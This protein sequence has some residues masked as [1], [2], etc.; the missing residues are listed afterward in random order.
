MF[1]TEFLQSVS[2]W[3][4]GGGSKQKQRRGERL[5]AL[6]QDVDVRFRSCHFVCYRQMALDNAALWKLLAERRLT[7]TISA[8]TL[9]PGV[10]KLFKGGVPYEGW[11]GV[12][13]EVMPKPADVILNLNSLY[14]CPEF[15][16]ALERERASITGY[17][18]GAGR[19]ANSQSEVVLRTDALDTATVYAMGGFSSDRDTLIR[20]MFG[21]EPTADL[22]AW[23]EEQQKL[24]DAE[25]GPAWLGGAPLQRVLQRMEPHIERLKVVKAEQDAG[26]D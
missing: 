9:V 17:S 25:L 13:F 3:Q 5:A 10:A 1:S 22:I 12:I 2:D 16:S 14:L 23:F 11:Q 7:E 20:M 8:W 4:R 26:R 6:A 19:Y 15:R 24:S 21:Q 18:D